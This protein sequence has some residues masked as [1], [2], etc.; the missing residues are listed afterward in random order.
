MADA[1]IIVDLLRRWR[2]RRMFAEAL[3]T[4]LAGLE[5]VHVAVE[6]I[7]EDAE[8]DGLR[9]AALAAAT[10]GA[11]RSHGLRVVDATKLFADVPG[12]PVLHVDVMT[13]HLDG[14]YAYSVRLELWQ[15]VRLV[16]T[17]GAQT[18]AVTWSAPQLVGSVAASRVS[19]L[20]DVVRDAADAFAAEC[21][22]ASIPVDLPPV[23]GG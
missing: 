23:Q 21:R 17:E 13:V 2:H 8:R 4:T 19:D 6:P 3:R 15:A 5:T 10:E 11:V 14:Q 9:Q 1:A 22:A 16:R 18:L 12:T 20:C 7:N